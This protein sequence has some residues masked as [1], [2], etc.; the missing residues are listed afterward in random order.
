MNDRRVALILRDRDRTIASAVVV[1][2]AV[3][4]RRLGN[5]GNKVVL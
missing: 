1:A 3:L 4:E 2:I 5:S